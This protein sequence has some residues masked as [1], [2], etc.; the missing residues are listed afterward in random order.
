MEKSIKG[1]NKWKEVPCSNVRRYQLGE[2][3]ELIYVIK[4]GFD[5]KYIVV[6]EDAYEYNVG[7]SKLM[8]KQKVE[9]IYNIT[10]DI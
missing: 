10:L 5:N 6:S 9:R 3:P 4:T 1:Y 8:T 2:N 7:N